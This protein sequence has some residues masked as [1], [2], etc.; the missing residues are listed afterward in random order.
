MTLR[1]HDNRSAVELAVVAKV[2]QV[3]LGVST[4]NG[5]SQIT[6]SLLGADDSCG[7]AIG[8]SLN[9]SNQVKQLFLVIRTRSRE[10]SNTAEVVGSSSAPQG[11]DIVQKLLTEGLG[12]LADERVEINTTQKERG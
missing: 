12:N 2:V 9:M 7:L 8:S 4:L 3:T 6:D 11:V 1:S 5:R 10:V